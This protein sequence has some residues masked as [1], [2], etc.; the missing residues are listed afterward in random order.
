[1]TRRIGTFG[2][3]LAF[4]GLVA[5]PMAATPDTLKR[6][7]ENI[8]QF[9]LDLALSPVVAMQ[10]VITNMNDIEDSP[11]VRLAYPVPG[12]FWTCFVQGGAAMLRGITGVIEFLPGL[13]LLFTDAELD[14]I[15][16]PADE[17]DGLVDFET[18]IFYVKFGINYTTPSY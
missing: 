16:D 13:A 7:I 5:S 8:T 9:P 18:D 10:T 17:Q 11:G 4:V 1:M 14:P 3:V 15:F 12:Y 6:S 2:L